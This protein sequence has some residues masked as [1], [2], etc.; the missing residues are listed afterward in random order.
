[1]RSNSSKFFCL[2]NLRGLT[3]AAIKGDAPTFLVVGG[4]NVELPHHCFNPMRLERGSASRV[5]AKRVAFGV[6][7]FFYGKHKH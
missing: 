5:V 6:L 2:N 7:N 1:M 3:D 4:G